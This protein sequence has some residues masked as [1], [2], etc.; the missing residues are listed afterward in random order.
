M[1]C[2]F[3][4]LFISTSIAF[5]CKVIFKEIAQ[6][7]LLQQNARSAFNDALMT[8]ARDARYRLMSGHECDSANLCGVCFY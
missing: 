6:L 5:Y 4:I 3:L 2:C 8:V 1:V 7:V